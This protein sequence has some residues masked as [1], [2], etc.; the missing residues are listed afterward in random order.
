M[1]RA[2]SAFLQGS[3]GQPRTAPDSHD[4]LTEQIRPVRVV[5]AM[6]K[7]LIAISGFASNV[8]KTKLVCDLLER[9]PGW[10]AIKVS[11]GH[12]RSCGKSPQACC[13]SPM[14]GEAPRVLSGRDETF[15]P[16]KDT[17]RYWSSGASNVHWVVCT[18][19]QVEEGIKTALDR[20]RAEGVFVEGT[21]ILK[22]LSVDYAIMVSDPI[23]GDIKSS[24]VGVMQKVD[25]VFVSG[26]EPTSTFRDGFRERLLRRGVKLGE[27][28]FY[29]EQDLHLLVDQISRVRARRP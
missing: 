19:E 6:H 21:S 17:G 5:L 18:S 7:T 9:H 12:R 26:L 8:G 29:G 20:V 24:A 4:T 16:G 28:S 13:I 3:P 27:V 14:L 2:Y 22:Y 11:R 23:A 25:A 15:A 1:A 10:E